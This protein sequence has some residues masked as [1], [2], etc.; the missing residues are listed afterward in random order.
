[1]GIRSTI[2][3]LNDLLHQHDEELWQHLEQKTKVA[4][5]GVWS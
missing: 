2:T 1:M 4:I 3:K 5:Q